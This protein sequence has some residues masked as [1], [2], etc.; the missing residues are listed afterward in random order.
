MGKKSLLPLTRDAATGLPRMSDQAGRFGVTEL[1]G[2]CR[3]FAR[4]RLLGNNSISL[5]ARQYFAAP[6]NVNAQNCYM[7]STRAEVIVWCQVSSM[8]GLTA[9]ARTNSYSARALPMA[10]TTTVL[11]RPSPLFLCRH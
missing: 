3:T 6:G 8:L 5:A 7:W 10:A 2:A 4:R 9:A 11:R 1:T